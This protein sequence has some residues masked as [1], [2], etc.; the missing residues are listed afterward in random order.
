MSSPHTRRKARHI[1]PKRVSPSA[2]CLKAAA[3][4]KLARESRG[5]IEARLRSV[6]DTPASS[7][8]VSCATTRIHQTAAAATTTANAADA[9]VDGNVDVNTCPSTS[10]TVD[11][12]TNTNHKALNTT[13]ANTLVN[14]RNTRTSTVN[15][16]N[17][18]NTTNTA[19]A[20]VINASIGTIAEPIMS[21]VHESSIASVKSEP[22]LAASPSIST[23]TISQSKDTSK[24]TR[25]SCN[26]VKEQ[27]QAVRRSP[28]KSIGIVDRSKPSQETISS[29]VKLSSFLSD[30]ERSKL[31]LSE[32][33]FLDGQP[34]HLC[35]SDDPP[36]FDTFPELG[37]NA[38]KR[39]SPSLSFSRCV[40]ICQFLLHSRN[41][42]S[43]IG[44]NHSYPT[45]S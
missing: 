5:C 23:S 10:K 14:A 2:S 8:D 41:L 3:A 18:T 42:N 37:T 43:L 40:C 27:Q 31:R 38:D 24:R 33:P 19:P 28:R 21:T 29:S 16:T 35:V 32:H 9:A 45:F 26:T 25:L 34:K 13:A 1:S 15:H 4:R 30:E 36:P 20:A 44:R 11:T 7:T 12:A 17:T 22:A 39:G 6:A